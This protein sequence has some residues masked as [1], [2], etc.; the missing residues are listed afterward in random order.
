[1][2]EWKIKR[3]KQLSGEELYEL[4][5]LRSEVFVVE[6]NCVY[7]DI[8]DKDREALHQLGFYNGKL[9]GYARLFDAGQ[10]FDDASIGRVVIASAYRDRKWGH[11]LM[12]FAIEVVHLEF[13][14]RN[15]TISAQL[16]L[17]KFYERHH[18][19]AVGET[20]KED[21]IPHIRMRRT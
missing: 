1:M 18:F 7:Q 4:L 16:Y 10:Y 20:Y 21:G 12:S 11:D 19:K 9:V 15:I 8:D 6:Q 14:Q 2:I 5:Q 3:F 17:Q 13:H